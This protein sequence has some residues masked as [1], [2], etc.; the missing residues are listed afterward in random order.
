VSAVDWWLLW[1]V[2]YVPLQL[3]PAVVTTIDVVSDSIDVFHS[4]LYSK[5]LGVN[6]S[7]LTSQDYSPLV[8]GGRAIRL[9]FTCGQHE[10]VNR[11]FGT[12]TAE[13]Q[14]PKLLL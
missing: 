6:H 11:A 2:L 13:S 7:G 10:F 8:C 1:V 4:S 9:C 14:L 5:G 12:S 3:E